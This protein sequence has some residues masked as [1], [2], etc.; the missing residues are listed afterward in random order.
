MELRQFVIFLIIQLL[1]QDRFISI[2]QD[3]LANNELDDAGMMLANFYNELLNQ[4]FE[5]ESF[6]SK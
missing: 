4:S 3:M 1:S 2:Y 5:A 6:N